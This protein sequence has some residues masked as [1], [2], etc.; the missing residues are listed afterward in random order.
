MVAASVKICTIKVGTLQETQAEEPCNYQ[1]I[2]AEGLQLIET[3][4]HDE[5]T[6]TLNHLSQH[7]QDLDLQFHQVSKGLQ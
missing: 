7:E 3:K 2:C 6:G 1:V 5:E 4:R